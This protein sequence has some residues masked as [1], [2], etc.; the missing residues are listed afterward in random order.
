MWQNGKI[1]FR[2]LLLLAVVLLVAYQVSRFLGTSGHL[3]ETVP[4]MFVAV[5]MWLWPLGLIVFFWFRAGLKS[6]TEPGADPTRRT[7]Y[8]GL[9]I[10]PWLMLI[11]FFVLF[12][13]LIPLWPWSIFYL[14]LAFAWATPP[15]FMM[16]TAIGLI[17][18]FARNRDQISGP[19]RKKVIAAILA[20]I[21][22]G[23]VWLIVVLPWFP[24]PE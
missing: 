17:A 5:S 24:E 10:G 7:I 20:L 22:V 23:S 2:W 16:S 12:L 1:R 4:F 13:A 8:M 6:W 9:R 21:M 19:E 3:S 14:I 15:V 11:A 18:G